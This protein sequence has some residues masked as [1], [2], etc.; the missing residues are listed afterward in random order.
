[1]CAEKD[2]VCMRKYVSQRQSLCGCWVVLCWREI[3]CANIQEVDSGGGCCK[4]CVVS[5]GCHQ[6]ACESCCSCW[7]IR[8]CFGA[9]LVPAHPKFV[10]FETHTSS[11]V[12]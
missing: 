4:V 3:V 1:M 6:G 8:S 12:V 10:C 5:G 11:A 2:L 7:V 9:K